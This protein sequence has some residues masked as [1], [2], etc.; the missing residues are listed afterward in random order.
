MGG[1]F[2]ATAFTLVLLTSSLTMAC[3]TSIHFKNKNDW[4]GY[5]KTP[6]P[7]LRSVQYKYRPRFVAIVTSLKRFKTQLMRLIGNHF[8]QTTVWQSEATLP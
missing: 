8:L 6:D 5:R 7:C 2:L 3:G 4:E 1:I